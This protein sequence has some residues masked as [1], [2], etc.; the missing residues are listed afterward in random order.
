[1][2]NRTTI[3]NI[4]GWLSAGVTDYQQKHGLQSWSQAAIV[5]MLEGLL[6]K[7]YDDPAEAY[8]GGSKDAETALYE[9]YANEN[10]D[11]SFATWLIQKTTPTWGGPRA[12]T[13][14]EE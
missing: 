7:G 3:S 5:L 10:V 2:S 12:S 14:D 13:S 4:P 9:E 8:I 1:M 11:V 6:A